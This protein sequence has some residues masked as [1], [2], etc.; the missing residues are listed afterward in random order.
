ML[1]I[2]ARALHLGASLLLFGLVFFGR[3]VLPGEADGFTRFR[4]GLELAAV[5]AI[6]LAGAAGALW[7]VLAAAGMAGADPW[8]S[9][10][11]S[12]LW[13]VA[14]QTR[15]GWLWLGRGAIAG[16]MLVLL[17]GRGLPARRGVLLALAALFAGSLAWAGHAG[18]DSS[19]PWHLAADVLHLLVAGIWPMGL[20]PLAALLLTA[21]T[22][23]GTA[24]AARRFSDLALPCV[25]VLLASGWINSWYLVGSWDHLF[26]T[27]Y[28]RELLV[29]LAAFALLV[30]LG[31]R[32]R[33]VL[34]RAAGP[35]PILPAVVLE[36]IL[37]LVVVGIVG[38][39]GAIA[40]PG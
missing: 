37:A 26:H 12:D 40:P 1:L 17:A 7:F 20:F 35:P 24:A 28:G 10:A 33:F 2:L 29:K 30:A 8:T 19:R 36:T 32:N 16:M 21:R 31:A 11:G 14:T 23:P 15:F 25:L 27:T 13:L 34:A 4:R 9:V 39:M 38:A 3:A 5:G 22:E 6:A 18:A